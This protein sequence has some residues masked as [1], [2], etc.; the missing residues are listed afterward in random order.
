M[1]GTTG[2]VLIAKMKNS[3]G[4]QCGPLLLIADVHPTT[5]D[6]AII[7]HPKTNVSLIVSSQK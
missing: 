4:C 7:L 2:L 6:V 1:I 3:G 5:S